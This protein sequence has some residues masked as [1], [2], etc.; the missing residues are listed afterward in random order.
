MLTLLLAAFAFQIASSSAAN[1]AHEPR[2]AA[3]AKS[4]QGG[5][6]TSPISIK[7][8][9]TTSRFEETCDW[10]RDLFGLAVLE[11]WNEPADKGCILGIRGA[12]GEAF[13][14]IAYKQQT[15]DFSGVSLQFRVADVG[16]FPVSDEPRFAHGEPKQRPWGSRYLVLTDPNGIKVI[17][18][19][20]T[21][22]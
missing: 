2:S 10:Y 12:D 20:G 7:T 13:L 8:R 1:P 16:R 18:F 11:K 6:L 22:I 21:S 17:I 3:V 4:K 9:I 5:P 19:S 15:P 14:E